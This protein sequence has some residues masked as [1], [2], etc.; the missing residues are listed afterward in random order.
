MPLPL[1]AMPFSY[2]SQYDILSNYCSQLFKIKQNYIDLN[3]TAL[4]TYIFLNFTK[5]QDEVL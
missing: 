5:T 1:V 3:V 4:D 2:Q